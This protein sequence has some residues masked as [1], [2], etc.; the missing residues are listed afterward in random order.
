MTNAGSAPCGAPL[1][2]PCGPPSPASGRRDWG[3]AG[4]AGFDP[5]GRALGEFR[6][7]RYAQLVLD[8]LEV[9]FDRLDAARQRPGDLARGAAAADQP[10][11]LQFA[12][13]ERIHR[14]AGRKRAAA[15][16]ERSA[17]RRCS[18]S[19]MKISPASALRMA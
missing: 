5:L 16:I 11:N 8:V 15:D 17:R 12:V 18:A 6:G 1:I 13:A 9:G 2:R 19:L 14:R 3:S 10:K 4:A 7:G